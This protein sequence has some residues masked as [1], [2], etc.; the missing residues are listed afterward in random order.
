M[1]YRVTHQTVYHYSEPVTL[2]HNVL[3]LT[4]RC[5]DR[6]TCLWSKL[7]V[8]PQPAVTN[9]WTD[10]FGNDSTFFTVQDRH[11][12]LDIVMTSEAVVRPTPL[13]VLEQSPPWDTVPVRLAN[14][15]P[16]A[17]A[18]GGWGEPGASAT[19]VLST[20]YS[21]LSTQY[22]GLPAHRDPA[23]LDAY[24]YT[25]D[26]LH[27]TATSQLADYARPSFP[28]GRPLLAAVQDLTRRIYSDFRYDPRATT[29]ATPL[30]D[31]LQNRRGVCQDFAHL[32]IGCLRSLGLAARYI[33]GYLL[34]TPPPGQARLIGADASHA[35][36][37]VYVP[38]MGWFDFDPTNNQIASEK[39]I[40][41]A[42]GRDYDDVSPIKGVILGG[43]RQSITVS[44]DV[45]PLEEQE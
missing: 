12:Q 1:T 5:T 34:T 28:P 15:E 14:G 4:P 32:E 26:S 38:G 17:S 42:W 21:V 36:L 43:G 40:T 25:F 22:S 37:A 11:E 3:R 20:Q 7:R 29:V 6:Q 30:G 8:T 44:V 23:D 41:V 39:H 19:G 9:R 13:P 31:V 33:S 2:C 18:T 27:I 10:Y 24:Q 16:G 35:W 45:I